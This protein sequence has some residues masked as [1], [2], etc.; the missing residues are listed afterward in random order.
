M[1]LTAQILFFSIFFLVYGLVN[2]Y[3]IKRG[4]AIVSPAFKTLYLIVLIFFAVSFIAGRFLERTDIPV[5]PQILTWAGSFWIAFMLYFFLSLVFVDLLRLINH[6]THIFPAF[7][8]GNTERAKKITGLAI[9]LITF[10]TV[11]AG[12][13]N[14]YFPVIKRLD[15]AINKKAGNLKELNIVMVSDLHLGSIL[16]DSFLTRIMEKSNSLNPDLVLFAGDVVDE[17]I[18]S[19]LKDHIGPTLKKFKSTYGLYAITG[20]HEYFSGA[21][22]AAKYL[23]EHGV[24]ML[25]DSVAEIDNSFYLVGREDRQ[26]NATGKKRKELA[27]LV[28][29]INPS[30]PVILMDHQPFKLEE[31][32]NAKVDL[33]LSGHTHN[34]QMWPFNYITDMVYEVGW[35][36]K[37][38]GETNIYVSC[39]AGTWGPPVRTG[40]RPEIVFIKL[41]FS[42]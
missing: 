42:G 10:I 21:D 18:G 19:I 16:G 11:A 20:N 24:V 17:D 14:T 27:E 25:R 41:R 37:K 31:A 12:H 34:G 15:L 26:K 28:K 32:V 1:K 6:F 39:G 5:L 8:T 4:L 36:Y 3:I 9:V 35:G 23:T 38:K 30:L 13:I 40:S 22:A 7:I 33:Q 2:Y 29:N